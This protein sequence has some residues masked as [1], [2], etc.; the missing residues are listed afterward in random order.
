[1]QSV[2]SKILVDPER[3]FE[4]KA[5]GLGGLGS[6]C[7]ATGALLPCGCRPEAARFCVFFIGF[8][9]LLSRA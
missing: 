9:I 7:T 8:R 3:E 6:P 5:W 4:I 2:T 1:M